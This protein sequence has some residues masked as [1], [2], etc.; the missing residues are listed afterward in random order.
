M[1]RTSSSLISYNDNIGDSEI[2][3]VKA[4]LQCFK[5]CYRIQWHVLVTKTPRI[6]TINLKRIQSY[7]HTILIVRHITY[8]HYTTPSTIKWYIWNIFTPIVLQK[9]IEDDNY[10]RCFFYHILNI[11]FFFFRHIYKYI[12]IS[13]VNYTLSF[14]NYS[15]FVPFKVGPKIQL[16]PSTSIRW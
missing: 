15:L 14:D 10:W 9:I 7:N 5:I 11:I 13:W 1:W 8:N 6:L 4:F 2:A 16:I 12:Y 3:Y